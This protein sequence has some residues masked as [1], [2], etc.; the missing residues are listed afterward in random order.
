M[1]RTQISLTSD[2]RRVLDREAARTGR[3][4][5]SLIRNAVDAAYGGASST[6]EDLS[7]MRQSFGSWA[8][9]TEDGAMYVD[10]LRS[11]ARLDISA[12]DPA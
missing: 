7:A 5:S 8:E 11:G 9:R 6:E 2:Q 3:S 12:G 10:R 1:D 4:I